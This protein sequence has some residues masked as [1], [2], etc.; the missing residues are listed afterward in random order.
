VA[1]AVNNRLA[2]F[3][4]G[5]CGENDA[6]TKELIGRAACDYILDGMQRSRWP[7]DVEPPRSYEY[8]RQSMWDGE[9]FMRSVGADGMVE[10]GMIMAG[11][12]S[13]CNDLVKR[14]A[15]IGVDQLIIHMQPSGLPHE[16]IMESI[17]LFGTHVIPEYQ[18]RSD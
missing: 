12:P 15:D 8:T 7:R 6:E 4:N 13:S 5:L 16:K 17:R 14:F 9:E 10:Q 18:Q 3:V 11:D 1:K 2:G